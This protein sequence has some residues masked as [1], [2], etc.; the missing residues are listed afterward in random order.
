MD[1]AV[2]A[3]GHR[4]PDGV[5]AASGKRGTSSFCHIV[6][7]VCNMLYHLAISCN[8]LPT[9]FALGAPGGVRKQSRFICTGQM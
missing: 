6:P 1:K 5:L 3:L 9:L 2:A 8:M 4:P 7:R